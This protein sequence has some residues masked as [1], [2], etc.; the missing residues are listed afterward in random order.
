MFT[1]SEIRG[2]QR[3][4]QGQRIALLAVQGLALGISAGAAFG[5]IIAVALIAVCV[6]PWIVY[7]KWGLRAEVVADNEA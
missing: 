5:P 2:S 1:A 7:W 3:A 6:L 4:S